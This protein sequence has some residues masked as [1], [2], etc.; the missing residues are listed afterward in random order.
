MYYP[1]YE[2]QIRLLLFLHFNVMKLFEFQWL[3]STGFG[4]EDNHL[5]SFS[6]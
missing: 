3:K 4:V 6:G 2:R 5:D 1:L